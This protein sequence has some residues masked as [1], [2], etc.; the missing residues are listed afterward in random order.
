[1]GAVFKAEDIEL[2][3]AVPL[4]IFPDQVL[5]EAAA[6]GFL[7]EVRVLS[8][9][10]HPN[11]AAMYDAGVERG[12][13]FITTELLEGATLDRLISARPLEITTVLSLAIEIAAGPAR[14]QI[15]ANVL[16]SHIIN[17]G[18]DVWGPRNGWELV[19]GAATVWQRSTSPHPDRRQ[20]AGVSGV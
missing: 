2:G 5:D 20:C 18:G 13:A 4:K 6:R 10:S 14:Q 11:I 19:A 7:E 1:M 8:R 16:A 3:K 15:D 12:R 9:L 17:P